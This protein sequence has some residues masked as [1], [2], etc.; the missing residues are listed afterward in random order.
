MHEPHVYVHSVA[1]AHT[2]YKYTYINKYVYV[3]YINKYVRI[4][5]T[6]MSVSIPMGIIIIVMAQTKWLGLIW[7][8]NE[9]KEREDHRDARR[10]IKRIRCADRR[11]YGNTGNMLYYNIQSWCCWTLNF[12]V[13]IHTFNIISSISQG[14]FGSVVLIIMWSIDHR[15]GRRKWWLRLDF[16][17][18]THL[19]MIHK[20]TNMIQILFGSSRNLSWEL[21]FNQEKHFQWIFSSG[22]NRNRKIL[23]IKSSIFLIIDKILLAKY[24]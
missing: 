15:R 5:N 1:C 20:S 19:H 16:G 24:Q 3:Y 14:F 8:I 9:R 13:K 12:H 10:E 6:C 22:I 11:H 4:T 18:V 17:N 7:K 23:M 2:K 21:F